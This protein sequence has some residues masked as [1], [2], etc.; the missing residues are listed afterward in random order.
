MTQWDFAWYVCVCLCANVFVVAGVVVC[1]S[2][3]TMET[4]ALSC[5]EDIDAGVSA[6]LAAGRSNMAT[7][8]S[9]EPLGR[10]LALCRDTHF[11][12][13]FTVFRC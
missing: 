6:A 12:M 9:S 13:S 4:V 1:G 11:K 8:K 10:C 5:R 7:T 2:Y 3:V